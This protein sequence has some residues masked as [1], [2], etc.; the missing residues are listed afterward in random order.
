VDAL[1]LAEIF[2]RSLEVLWE[3]ASCELGGRSTLLA[4]LVLHTYTSRHLGA[5]LM[6]PTFL[7]DVADQ[8]TDHLQL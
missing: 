3:G 2:R 1:G 6:P 5:S 8:H 7:Q 4:G